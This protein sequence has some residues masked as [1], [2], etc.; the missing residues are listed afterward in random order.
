MLAGLVSANSNMRRKIWRRSSNYL[1]TRKYTDLVTR[2]SFSSVMIEGRENMP[3]DGVVMLAPNHCC[4]LMD[5][6]VDL[7][8]RPDSFIVFGARSDVFSNPKIA[9]ILRWLKI[10]PI[11]RERDGLQEVAKNIS[12]FNEAIDCIAHGVPFCMYSEGRHRAERGMLPVRKGIFR[13]AKMAMEHLGQIVYVVPMVEDYEYLFRQTGKVAIRLGEPINVNKFLQE[14]PDLN[15]S[16]SYRGLCNILQ[17]RDEAMLGKL[18]P[19][20]EARAAAKAEGQNFEEPSTGSVLLRVLLGLVMLAPSLAVGIL[21]LPI[22]LPASLICL[23]FKDKAW[24]HTIY[25]CCRLLMP[26]FL[27]FEWLWGRAS[28]FYFELLNDIKK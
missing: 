4:A 3:Q 10:L 13:I 7:L 27:P 22:R 5:P 8:L 28:N 23:R 1:R 24:T 17:E 21:A 18:I 9:E 14:H 12:T 2:M 25:F 20:S 16:A 11:A 6:L 26:I 19:R 15:E